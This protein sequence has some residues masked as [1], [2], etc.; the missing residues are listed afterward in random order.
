MPRPSPEVLK[1][2]IQEAQLQFLKDAAQVYPCHTNRASEAGHPCARYLTY[3]RTHWQ[4]RT[5]PDP[6]RQALYTLGND[7]E[8][9]VI[10][11]WAIS[12][13]K[14]YGVDL[15]RPKDRGWEDKRT[16][17]TGHL[18]CFLAE[19]QDDGETMWVPGEIKGIA[20]G[21]WDT[22]ES[23]AD[24]LTSTRSWVRKWAVQLPF[25]CLMDAKPYGRFIFFSKETGRIRD[26]CV[27]LDDCLGLLDEVSKKLE[28]VNQHVAA[29]TLPDRFYEPG[30]PSPLCEDCDFG[31]VCL[32]GSSYDSAVRLMDDPAAEH[33]F[34][35][36]E[37][38]RAKLKDATA[39]M[40]TEVDALRKQLSVYFEDKP[41]VAIAGRIVK[42]TRVEVG[43]KNGYNFWKWTVAKEK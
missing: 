42:G 23:H 7:I 4:H 11:N 1:P 3:C 18:D 37:A 34:R 22:V 16:G 9:I 28:V 6:E 21:T 5:A 19:K 10:N 20:M 39:G 40:E 31:H 24:M 27:V 25:Y 43:P 38:L 14:K 29:G 41:K 30:P 32:P 35:R 13:L 12:R 2:Y 33:L 8:D 26:F 17:T 36:W 15:I